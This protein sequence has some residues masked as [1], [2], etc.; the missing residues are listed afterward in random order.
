M[1]MNE[2]SRWTEEEMETAKKGEWL[3]AALITLDVCAGPAA[4]CGGEEVDTC[5]YWGSGVVCRGQALLPGILRL[6]SSP[7][8]L[9]FVLQKMGLCD[10]V[11]GDHVCGLW[12]QH[13]MAL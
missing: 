11:V 4:S 8:S 5:P 12:G 1:E 7:Q 10:H 6:A 3:L 2:S 13:I 9:G